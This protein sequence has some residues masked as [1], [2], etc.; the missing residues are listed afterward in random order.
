MSLV[1]AARSTAPP[2]ARHSASTR[3]VLPDPTGPPMPTWRRPA[4]AWSLITIPSCYYY[5]SI[6]VRDAE[7]PEERGGVLRHLLVRQR[8]VD[9]GRAPM[10]LLLERD[11]PPGFREGGQGLAE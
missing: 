3:A 7:L 5:G 9:V 11:H 8:P 1:T 4:R 2:R 10:G 6:G